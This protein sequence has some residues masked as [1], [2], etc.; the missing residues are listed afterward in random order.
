MMSE[1]PLGHQLASILVEQGACSL[2]LVVAIE[3]EG[4][5]SRMEGSLACQLVVS[6]GI[7]STPDLPPLHGELVRT[8]R[9]LANELEKEAFRLGVA[10][11]ARIVL[12]GPEGI[13]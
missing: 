13:R 7:A 2:A 1:S 6:T 5:T 3:Q 4:E 9:F 11:S 8:L 12:S 10:P